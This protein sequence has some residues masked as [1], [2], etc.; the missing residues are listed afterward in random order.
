MFFENNYCRPHPLSLSLKKERE[1]RIYS[2]KQG[3]TLYTKI[4]GVFLMN[5]NR[6]RV[7]KWQKV[8]TP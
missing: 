8:Y 6:L 4:L 7:Y 3:F 5:I 2:F 1:E